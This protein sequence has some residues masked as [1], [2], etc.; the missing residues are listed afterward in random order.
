MVPWNSTDD[1]CS[2]GGVDCSIWNGCSVVT[3][4]DLRDFGLRGMLPED[5][6]LL[7]NLR[8]LRLGQNFGLFGLLPNTTFAN[9]SKLQYLDL[10]RTSLWG[11]ILFS[12][13]SLISLQAYSSQFTAIE[14]SSCVNLQEVLLA[15]TPVRGFPSSFKSN[16]L[17][18]F[19]SLQTIDLSSTQLDSFDLSCLC[20]SQKLGFVALSRNRLQGSIPSCL[21][22]LPKLHTLLLASNNFI[23]LPFD[24]PYPSLAILD[25]ERNQITGNLG[26]A[27]FPALTSGWFGYNNFGG[28]VPSLHQ[29]GSHRTGP[30][31]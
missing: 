31:K 26:F 12:H 22:E 7:S 1:F 20:Q 28:L 5:L 23:Y 14:A 2:W 18:E 30:A 6:G 8:V 4:L 25:V 9:M 29:P 17:C 3:S 11:A 24:A 16:N 19:K 27:Y 10:A 15:E 21:G 13:D